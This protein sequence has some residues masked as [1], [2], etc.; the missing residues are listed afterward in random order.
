[1]QLLQAEGLPFTLFV[2]MAEFDV[3]SRWFA[4]SPGVA[5]SA[6]PVSDPT[7]GFFWQLMLAEARS[8]YD[9][10]I[11]PSPWVWL[12]WDGI[13]SFS[14]AYRQKRGPTTARAALEGSVREFGQQSAEAL[15][16]I[17]DRGECDRSNPSAICLNLD[18]TRLATF[19]YEPHLN[20]FFSFCI[21][22]RSCGYGVKGSSKFYANLR[23]QSQD[24]QLPGRAPGKSRLPDMSDGAQGRN[25]PL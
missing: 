17:P 1:M 14:M 25:P 23:T 21:Q 19:P 22:V 18:R 10:R 24:L 7:P 8:A 16:V 15:F 9:E 5:L 11:Q 6:V 13:E 2:P 4:H 12:L 3:Y 20:A